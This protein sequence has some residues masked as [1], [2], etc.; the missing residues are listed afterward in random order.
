MPTT[1][2]KEPAW[3]D[4]GPCSWWHN[5][6]E[7]AERWRRDEGCQGALG[8]GVEP[9]ERSG[10]GSCPLCLWETECW[11]IHV[12]SD[13]QAARPPGECQGS[14]GPWGSWLLGRLVS[15]CSPL[16]GVLMGLGAVAW[17]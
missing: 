6:L 4:H 11:P 10:R 17:F 8:G 5:R 14:G 13:P 9:W 3:K 16:V 1:E 7:R 12:R 2:R 15:E